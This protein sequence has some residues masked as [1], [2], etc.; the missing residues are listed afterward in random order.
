MERKETIAQEAIYSLSVLYKILLS[1][2]IFLLLSTMMMAF[3]S[4]F[5]SYDLTLSSPGEFISKMALQR[6][7]FLSIFLI[8][9][10][11]IFRFFRNIVRVKT[12]PFRTRRCKR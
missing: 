3:L 2:G 9:I 6:A 5:D 1:V 7:F 12:R 10:S 4:L 11:L 8:V